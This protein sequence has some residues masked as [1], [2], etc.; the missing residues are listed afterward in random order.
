MERDNSHKI[1]INLAVNFNS[2]AHVERDYFMYRNIAFFSYISTHTLTWSVTKHGYWK[3]HKKTISTHTLTW[4]VT[5][6][7]IDTQ[8]ELAISTH[9]LTWSVTV[10]ISAKTTSVCISTHTLTWSV[11]GNCVHTCYGRCISTHTLTWSVTQALPD[12]TVP[13][14]FQLTRSRGA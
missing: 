1:R 12:M 3:F 13:C 14:Q 10:R 2:H 5:A 9:T 4:S 7:N 8:T 6:D 11:T